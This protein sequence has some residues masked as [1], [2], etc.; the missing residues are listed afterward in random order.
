MWRIWVYGAAA[1][2]AQPAARIDVNI[3]A[4]RL[5]ALM[6]DALVRTVTLAPGSAKYPTPRGSFAITSIEWNPWWI[7]PDSP[8][9][10][11][12]HP[13]PPGPTNPMGRVKLN[14]RPM[15]YLH[16]T[17]FE[18]SLGTA[19]S[20]GCVRMANGDAVAIAQ[21]VERAGGVQLTNDEIARIA[22]DTSRTR[23][24]ELPNPVPLEIRYDLAEV[25][26]DRL[27]V[28]RDVY[29]IGTR[30]RLADAY[31]ALAEAG[32]D[33]TLVDDQQ[34]R[35]LVTRIKQSGNSAPLDSLVGFAPRDQRAA[36]PAA[37]RLVAAA[38]ACTLVEAS[39]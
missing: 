26:G 7:P 16:G 9:A 28:Y 20:H 33:T 3:P 14:F 1:L 4:Y 34:M 24:I 11:R 31:A 39:W 17:P 30:S 8:W 10:A 12:E 25:Y 18:R 37:R 5:E 38:P 29:G 35:R 19:A 22:E 6:G 13:T 21:F 36:A 32:I 15:Y 2:L 23:L 27:F